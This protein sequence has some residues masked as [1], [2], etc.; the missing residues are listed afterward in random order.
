MASQ[1]QVPPANGEGGEAKSTPGKTGKL[2]SL[3]K[4]DLIKYVKKQA[5]QMQ[6]LKAQC[7][8]LTK[9]ANEM[10]NQQSPSGDAEYSAKMVEL[11]ARAKTAEEELAELKEER[12]GM[13]TTYNTIQQ[14][15]EQNL[16]T[17]KAL[18]EALEKS[19]EEKE[20]L[21][22]E[23]T[24]WQEDL[25][26]ANLKNKELSEQLE[27]MQMKQETMTS[28]F[29]CMQ[30]DQNKMTKENEVLK[31]QIVLL[32]AARD[33]VMESL[34]TFKQQTREKANSANELESSLTVLTSERDALTGQLQTLQKTEADAR[35][36]L[37]DLKIHL[38]AAEEEM[39]VSEKLETER[40]ALL[41]Q[42]ETLQKTEADTRA[43]LEDLKIHL[44]GAEDENKV[45]EKLEAE[46]R[47]EEEDTKA[48]LEEEIQRLQ[49]LHEEDLKL[50]DELLVANRE[51][52]EGLEKATDQEVETQK[53]R[54]NLANEVTKLSQTLQLKENELEGNV[55]SQSEFH[56]QMLEREDK[57]K[58]AVG[59][60]QESD[61][62]I[63]ELRS[64]LEELSSELKSAIQF[65]KSS[66][67]D[68][69]NSKATEAQLMEEVQ[70]L[71]CELKEALGS[72]S[73]LKIQV[74][75][76]TNEKLQLA[77]EI[78]NI[79]MTRDQAVSDLEEKAEKDEIVTK[80]QDQLE[81]VKAEKELLV[82]EIAAMRQV[83]DSIG[84]LNIALEA[85]QAEKTKM[86]S[87]SSDKESVISALSNDVDSLKKERDNLVTR[88]ED[89]QCELKTLKQNNEGKEE[90]MQEK[91]TATEEEVV[92]LKEQ[93][94]TAT[95]DYQKTLQA[96]EVERDR[97]R[98]ETLVLKTAQSSSSNEL[99]E[100]LKHLQSERD[101]LIDVK[102]ELGLQV[103][104]LTEELKCAQEDLKVSDVLVQK[105][106]QDLDREAQLKEE[107]Y[108]HRQINEELQNELGAIREAH[109]E[110]MNQCSHVESQLKVLKESQET[111]EEASERQTEK[112]QKSLEEKLQQLSTEKNEIEQALVN[113]RNEKESIEKDLTLSV[114][115]FTLE[116]EELIANLKGQEAQFQN[117]LE[118]MSDSIRAYERDRLNAEEDLENL[119]K[120][121][122]SYNAELTEALKMITNDKEHLQSKLDLLNEQLMTAEADK[123]KMASELH[124]KDSDL[125]KVRQ[126]IED[127]QAGV[128]EAAEN[129]KMLQQEKKEM[130]TKI[131]SLQ[132]QSTPTQPAEELGNRQALESQIESLEAKIKTLEVDKQTFKANF[133]KLKKA[134]QTK[135]QRLQE[136][137]EAV[138][139][140]R[141]TLSVKLDNVVI[142]EK[143]LQEQ[144]HE[145]NALIGSLKNDKADF[146]SVKENL[147]SSLEEVT[148][149]KKSLFADLQAV[150]AQQTSSD[151]RNQDLIKRLQESE[152]S[153]Q[154]LMS[155][156]QEVQDEVVR[157]EE[158]VNRLAGDLE[159]ALMVKKTPEEVTDKEKEAIQHTASEDTSL[160]QLLDEKKKQLKETEEKAQKLRSLAMKV[161]KELEQAKK[162]IAAQ[163]EELNVVKS[164]KDELMKKTDSMNQQLTGSRQHIEN[165][166]SLQLEYEKLQ[167]FLDAEKELS[168]ELQ[169]KMNKMLEDFK[170]LSRECSQTKVAKEELAR[171][172]DHAVKEI[173]T[174]ECSVAELK[175]HL[176]A[177]EEERDTEKEEKEKKIKELSQAVGKIKEFE[178]DVGKHKVNFDTTTKQLQAALKE[179]SQSSLMDLEIADYE[180]TVSNLN[181]I[182][183]E[184]DGKM[185][186][187]QTEIERLQK[188]NESMLKEIDACDAQRVQADE[189]GN[190]LKALLMKSKKDL[191]D[192]KKI[193]SDQ[194]SNEAALQGQLESLN[195]QAEALKVDLSFLSAENQKLNSQLHA[196]NDANLRTVR[197][198]EQ[199]NQTLKEDLELVH[200]E[201]TQTKDEFEN[202]KVRV[203][204]VLKQQKTRESSHVV[205]ET[206]MQ[207]K[208]H[209]EKVNKQLKTKL[210]EVRD[211]L[212]TSSTELELLQDEHDRQLQRHSD[213]VQDAQNK[214][215]M[216]REKMN[217]LRMESESGNI[218][219][220]EA[221]R[222]LT[223]Q[224]E[225]LTN[226]FKTQMH[227]LQ[228]EHHRTVASLQQ[229]LDMMEN[230]VY[231]I[232]NEQQQAFQQQRS[233]GLAR[234][235]MD[236]KEGIQDAALARPTLEERE[237][238]EGMENTDGEASAAKQRISSTTSNAP[239]IPLSQLLSESSID[240]SALSVVSLAGSTAEE[241]HLKAELTSTRKKL[242]H[243]NEIMSDNEATIMRLTEQAKVLKEE[244]RRLER[245]QQRENAISNMEY[246]K[247][248]VMKFLVPAKPGERQHLVPVLTTM[249]QLS[250]KEREEMLAVIE[251]DGEVTEKET[252]K[253]G[254]YLHRWS[255]GIV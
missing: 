80:L 255:G 117:K 69:E 8:K 47:I 45:S 72:Q 11:E 225:A 239:M 151:D 111:D 60:K 199:K 113:L 7:E 200:Q 221:I 208:D 20:H 95:E 75:Q 253:W 126:E 145:L 164:E 209:L 192:A 152:A 211:E 70:S 160:Q 31:D 79:K 18:E 28:T 238:G 24:R 172:C 103:N 71:K 128:D 134:S 229:Q 220:H 92:V 84:E 186:E 197:V 140:E 5:M 9:E 2:D 142:S 212:K 37:E 222:E 48:R 248:V 1:D 226:A 99:Q 173:H 65:V 177:T 6:K 170:N 94:C 168:Q 127:R 132:T 245:N 234:T 210:Q 16:E 243:F 195:Q 154:N 82:K 217:K 219:H 125:Q 63:Q 251:E 244:I 98:E 162:Q 206:E 10:S 108:S 121:N 246:L 13:L 42:L 230:Q 66:E 161:K 237:Q 118:E 120:T 14:Q 171:S 109:V 58:S 190:K 163:T 194:R 205:M 105:Q 86:V 141:T 124:S 35:A 100:R 189:R 114:E 181:H 203:H 21:Q 180:K 15:Q 96:A 131:E 38:Q 231:R 179:A 150:L 187:F 46:R 213:M 254:S 4:D 188:R 39:K 193:E 240:S 156:L 23:V 169:K 88:E 76:L 191:A 50:K 202:Y 57:L 119:K 143:S 167:D 29:Q 166:Q 198:L 101:D 146:E 159:K 201:M 215:S 27:C 175:S 249:L 40:D 87:E 78:E 228:D 25:S 115:N 106:K 241:E 147:E 55:Q 36:E 67:Q 107:L 247:N 89:L 178:L 148:E 138:K 104:R 122:D 41:G 116:K 97:A 3:A 51:L 33:Q 19:G 90:Q 85:L 83:Q 129:L 91:L 216:W 30:D 196:S 34:Q 56:N 250:D 17:H 59:D 144:V 77:G 223:A 207:E 64:Q 157:K 153:K 252:N 12:E 62:V 233:Q 43:E 183:Q 137:M 224:N 53:D 232:Q 227:K 236:L 204:S 130:V 74:D 149:E 81:I 174:L 218:Q 32:T 136:Q 235:G 102:Q 158:E 52:Q 68:L 61:K 135:L 112:S 49:G 185:M 73:E 214:E 54:D 123:S 133:E 22:R 139:E 26:K 93:L 155:K 176:S 182:I 44:Q 184:K 165:Y 110:A 242:E